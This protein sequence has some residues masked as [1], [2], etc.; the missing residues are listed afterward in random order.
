MKI[1]IMNFLSI[2]L[3]IASVI[4]I[5]CGQSS[6]YGRG[7][8]SS[9][10]TPTSHYTVHHGNPSGFI[11]LA[12][13]SDLT[14]EESKHRSPFKPTRKRNYKGYSSDEDDISSESYTS[15]EYSNEA[16]HQP[17]NSRENDSREYTIGTHIR[18]QHPIT[19]PKKT[20][21]PYPTKNTKYATISNVGGYGIDASHEERGNEPY[22][23]S[24]SSKKQKYAK[25]YE[26]D[27]F[28]VIAPPNSKIPGHH[29]HQAASA[30]AYGGNY[31]VF[32]P[33]TES[34]ENPDLAV[35]HLKA[36][37]RDR[38]KGVA[39]KKQIE[40]YLEDQEK[41]L[42]DALKLQLLNS[43]KFQKLLKTAEKEHQFKQPEF[44]DEYIANIPTQFRESFH[45]G[46]PPKSIRTRRRP[47][48][49]KSSLSKPNRKYRSA[50]VIEV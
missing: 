27:P 19:I 46:V 16:R 44:E 48:K 23:Q 42:D 45:K 40:K 43:S 34:Y 13:K 8:Y 37:L 12:Y 7:F 14:P 15:D 36:N 21:I 22:L 50:F 17:L 18:V 47:P 10:V 2:L 4:K 33:E 3:L 35:K 24:T 32:E 25:L 41:L 31:N 39:S 30:S 6:S 11:P 5:E 9:V 28:H 49:S 29:H 1:L 26:P 20:T 38:Y